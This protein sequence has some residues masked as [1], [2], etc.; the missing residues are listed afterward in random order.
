[1]GIL[2]PRTIIVAYINTL[3]SYDS[4]RYSKRYIAIFLAVPLISGGV[5]SYFFCLSK[6]LIN[7]LVASLS[8]FAALLFNLLL[9]VYSIVEKAKAK[10]PFAELKTRFLK[11]IYADISFSILVS[12]STVS[13]L[14]AAFFVTDKRSPLIIFSFCIYSLTLNFILTLF[15]IL[16]RIHI[17]LSKEFEKPNEAPSDPVS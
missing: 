4:D 12:V 3:K 1:M 17:L 6:D 9:L 14:F 15:M 5:L 10:E 7:I 16:Q 8:I 2:S 11:E 13:L